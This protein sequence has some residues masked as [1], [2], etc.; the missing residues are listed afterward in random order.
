MLVFKW[1][2][3]VF[4]NKNHF[5]PAT[6]QSA[7]IYE[8]YRML[9]V[10]YSIDVFNSS[11][12]G[13]YDVI[14]GGMFNSPKDIKEGITEGLSN[15]NI[16]HEIRDYY[17]LHSFIPSFSA[18]AHKNPNQSWSNPLNHNL[19]CTNETPFDSYFGHEKN[20]QHTSFTAES[21]AWLLK[22]LAGQPQAPHFPL[23]ESTLSGPGKVC[24]S[25]TYSFND[26]C[27][28]PSPLIYTE[29]GTTI[30]GWSVSPNLQIVSSTA[31]SVIVN[32]ISDGEGFIKATFQNGQTITKK[33]W[34]GKPQVNLIET[35]E[36]GSWD[37]SLNDPTNNNFATQGITSI[38]W[39]KVSGNGVIYG[40]GYYGSVDGSP[41]RAWVVTIKITTNRLN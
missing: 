14:P 22:E 23:Q 41:T 24:T 2:I 28:L 20:T 11:I 10:S 27:K 39:A 36:T 19:I 4:R 34:V 8:G 6:N 18:I 32:K 38:T 13:S 33:I 37:L 29:N 21:V 31:Y 3:T 12:H 35:P 30:N 40:N 26:T 1:S 16:R 15:E 9:G 17:E 5:L 25:A 7:R